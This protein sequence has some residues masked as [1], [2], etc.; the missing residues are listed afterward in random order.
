MIRFVNGDMFSTTYDAYVNPVNCKGVM[1]K[2]LA[3]EFKKRYPMYFKLYKDI[4]DQGK[5]KPGYIYW[6]RD[7]TTN[8]IIINFATKDHWKDPS[9]IEWI[10]DGCTKL[11]DYLLENPHNIE[12]IAIPKLGCGLGGLDWSYV[13]NIF[14][15]YFNDITNVDIYV[16]E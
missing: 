9:K 6:T 13:R 11:R 5:L 16:Y 15:K 2:G 3:L 7:I 1:G 4:C 14:L 12:D 10:D 8:I